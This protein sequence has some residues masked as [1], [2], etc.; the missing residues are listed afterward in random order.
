VDINVNRTANFEGE[1]CA[2]VF[3][4]RIVVL[5]E[6]DFL[7]WRLHGIFDQRRKFL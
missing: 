6:F 2:G 5:G 1:F 4:R 7:C 3:E